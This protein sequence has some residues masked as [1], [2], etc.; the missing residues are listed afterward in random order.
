MKKRR[1][2]DWTKLIGKR[3]E[4]RHSGE[5]VQTGLVDNAMPDSSVIWLA[6][7]GVYRRALFE[8]AHGFEIWVEYEAQNQ[9]VAEPKEKRPVRGVFGSNE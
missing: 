3:V 7:E 8:A 4:V 5:Q 2:S 9:P 6:P 1:V